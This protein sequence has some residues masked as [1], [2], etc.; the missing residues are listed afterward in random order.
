MGGRVILAKNYHKSHTPAKIISGEVRLATK[1]DSIQP[2]MRDIGGYIRGSWW[3]VWGHLSI[4]WYVCFECFTT[5]AHQGANS[6][7]RRLHWTDTEKANSSCIGAPLAMEDRNCFITSLMGQ[8][9]S[10]PLSSL[11]VPSEMIFQWPAARTSHITLVFFPSSVWCLM[12]LVTIFWV[13]LNWN[14]HL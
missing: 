2:K 10:L 9:W 3:T 11:Q 1:R 12:Y 13:Q 4:Y 7:L 5:E 8:L 14:N 6:V